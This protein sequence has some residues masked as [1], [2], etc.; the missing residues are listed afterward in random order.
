MQRGMTGQ[1]H[2]LAVGKHET[3]EPVER[4]ASG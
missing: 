1:W 2:W 3:G 4:E